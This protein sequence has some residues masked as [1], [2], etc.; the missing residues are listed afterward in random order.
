MNWTAKNLVKR[1]AKK[2]ESEKVKTMAKCWGTSLAK[3]RVKM[4]VR[5]TER[6]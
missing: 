3:T 4:K 6:N 2:R 1:M 5:R